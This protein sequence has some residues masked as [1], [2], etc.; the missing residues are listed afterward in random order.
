[1]EGPAATRATPGR[2][3]EGHREKKDL[4]RH[5]NTP[6]LPSLSMKEDGI[7]SVTVLTWMH[8]AVCAVQRHINRLHVA[9]NS[10]VI[11]MNKL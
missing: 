1:M 5:K 11:I 4:V 2:S 7:S 3:G 8:I 6:V 10:C 9:K